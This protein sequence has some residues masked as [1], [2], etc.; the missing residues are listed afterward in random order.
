MRGMVVTMLG[1][2]AFAVAGCGDDGDSGSSSRGGEALT[3]AQHIAQA[4]K[5]CAEVDNATDQLG[6]LPKG[7]RVE[8]IV[9]ILEGHLAEWRK[10]VA[11]LKALHAPS[12]GKA[13]IDAYFVAIDESITAYEGLAEVLVDED[14]DEDNVNAPRLAQKA[15]RLFD[16]QR[17]LATRYGFKRCR[18]I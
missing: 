12:E 4:D 5:I 17:R 2:A 6:A 14:E 15:N 11:R 18:S 7:A 9:T 1:S 10:G 8:R 3:K 16:E 13:T